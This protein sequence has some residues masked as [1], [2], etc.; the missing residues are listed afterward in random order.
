MTML[1][2][3]PFAEV[4]ALREWMDRA[5]G[6]TVSAVRGTGGVRGFPIDVY[7]QD[8]TLVLRA[9]LPGVNPDEV[10]TTIEQNRLTIRARRPIPEEDEKRR[11]L[12]R[13]LWTGELGRALMLPD[14]LDGANAEYLG[15]AAAVDVVVE[16]VAAIRRALGRG[17]RVLVHCSAGLHR[18]GT[19]AYAVMRARVWS[20]DEAR[21]GLRRMRKETADKVDEV[22]AGNPK[23]GNRLDIVRLWSGRC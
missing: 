12:M 19:V 13:E 16:A 15:S 7:E 6:T 18:T 21:E 1:R 8:D 4:D 14:G 11:Y 2:R 22:G 5:F 23:S 3:S 17:D 9:S 10:T 20:R